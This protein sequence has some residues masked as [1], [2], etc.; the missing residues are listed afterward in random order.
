MQGVV[1]GVR[2]AGLHCVL[3][4]PRRSYLE[5]PGPFED[6]E[7]KKLSKAI[8]IREFRVLPDR[9]CASDMCRAAG[10]GLIRRLD[11]DPASI[12]VLVFVS[13]NPD[14]AL[15]VTAAVL[16]HHLGLPTSAACF[17]VPLGC[18]GYTY[19]LWIAAQLLGGSSAKRALVL[20][21]DDSTRWLRPDDKGSLPLFGDAG[22]A[23]ALEADPEAPP[24]TVAM[25]TDGAGARHLI[26]KGGGRRGGMMPGPESLD[27]EDARRRFEDSR[28]HMNGMEVFAFTLRAV[29]GLIAETLDAAGTDLDGIDYVVPHQANKMMLDHL[30]KKIGVPPEKYVIDME[31]FGNTSS[32]SIPLAMCS[33]L[34]GALASGPKT[35]LMAGFGV[36]WSWGTVL[37]EIGPIARPDITEIPEDLSPMAL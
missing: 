3:P 36:G 12:E 11:W 25:G 5:D 15:P 26:M 4:E 13:Q 9:W 18:S 21:G 7:I 34:G 30:R 6:A 17:D 8:G 29:P 27:A 10:E 2:I 37:T 23:T 28:L 35:V 31:T 16:Q 1:N 24:M 19:G 32:A 14:Y 33:S 22:A 20:C